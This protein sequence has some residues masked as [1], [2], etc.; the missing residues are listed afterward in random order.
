MEIAAEVVD[1]GLLRMKRPETSIRGAKRV[2]G[3]KGSGTEKSCGAK[4]V[5]GQGGRV[6]KSHFVLGFAGVLRREDEKRSPII[7]IF[8]LIVSDV[9]CSYALNAL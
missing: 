5:R 2:A 1:S 8:P 4:G 7:I 3:P 9:F 6:P